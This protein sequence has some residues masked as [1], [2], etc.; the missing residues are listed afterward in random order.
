MMSYDYFFLAGAPF[1]GAPLPAAAAPGL[2]LLAPYLERLCCLPL[3]P[4]VSSAPRIC[5]TEHL[6]DP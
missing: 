4:A 6:E 2:G 3:T 1:A 5:G